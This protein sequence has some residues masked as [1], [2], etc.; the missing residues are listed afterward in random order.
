MRVKLSFTYT[1]YR[2]DL[3]GDDFDANRCLVIEEFLYRLQPS[4][5]I[6]STLVD[7]EH[8]LRR[9]QLSGLNMIDEGTS[10]TICL[11]RYETVEQRSGIAPR[12][13]D[14]RQQREDSTER[15]LERFMV[16]LN[17]KGF[18]FG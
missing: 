6:R 5:R 11:L 4:A 3:I 8:L 16:W 2:R 18:R 1:G 9:S 12:E 15:P 13:R 10:E 14:D 17:W 7:G